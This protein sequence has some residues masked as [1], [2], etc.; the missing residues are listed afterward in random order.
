MLMPRAGAQPD[1]ADRG[2]DVNDV[3]MR[4]LNTLEWFPIDQVPPPRGQI[5]LWW[6]HNPLPGEMVDMI[7]SGIVNDED[8]ESG[9][10]GEIRLM[11]HDPRLDYRSQLTHWARYP[12]GPQP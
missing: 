1:A 6:R 8:S 7:F 11:F 10:A 9:K 2:I 5:L 4:H 12:A 3:R